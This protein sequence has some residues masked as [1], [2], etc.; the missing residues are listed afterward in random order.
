MTVSKEVLDSLK[1][2]RDRLLNQLIE[3]EE[4]GKKNILEKIIEIDDI[5]ESYPH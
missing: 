1:N 2:E 4:E 3:G 5:I